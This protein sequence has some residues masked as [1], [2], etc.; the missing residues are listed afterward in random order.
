MSFGLFVFAFGFVVVTR[1]DMSLCIL[2]IM[3]EAMR[4]HVSAH[5]ISRHVPNTW[6]DKTRLHAPSPTLSGQEKSDAN[7][8]DID[9]DFQQWRTLLGKDSGAFCVS[10]FSVLDADIIILRLLLT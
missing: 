3:S 2:A 10:R 1:P 9:S 7:F 8:S 4:D 6:K 5:L